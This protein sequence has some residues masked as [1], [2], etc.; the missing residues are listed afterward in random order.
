VSNAGVYVRLKYSPSTI[1]AL[2]SKRNCA[3]LEN[4]S[5]RISEGLFWNFVVPWFCNLS[6]QIGK[7][8]KLHQS[9]SFRMFGYRIGFSNM[10]SSVI[11]NYIGPR[12]TTSSCSSEIFRRRVRIN[13]TINCPEVSVANRFCAPYVR[14]QTF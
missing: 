7:L 14:F 2:F 4:V 1:T 8:D 9:R 6:G 10:P 3:E 12:N 11:A 5:S 13:G